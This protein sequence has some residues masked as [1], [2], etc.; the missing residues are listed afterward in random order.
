VEAYRGRQGR[1]Q[2]NTNQ[3]SRPVTSINIGEANHTKGVT[4][5]GLGPKGYT[6][7]E[8]NH[9]LWEASGCARI[10]ET[11]DFADGRFYL[12]LPGY[13]TEGINL[14]QLFNI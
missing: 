14:S 11:A 7:L 4:L 3:I 8:D 5:S 6:T 2:A 10:I 9:V 1:S 12:G 13:S